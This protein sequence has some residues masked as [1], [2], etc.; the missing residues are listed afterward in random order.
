MY[1]ITLFY[2][3]FTDD[4]KKMQRMK[5]ELKNLQLISSNLLCSI[6][7]SDKKKLFD[8]KITISPEILHTFYKFTK[9]YV[10]LATY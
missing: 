6:K 8:K 1:F 4:T 5:V 3:T 7:K 10:A 2:F 9:L